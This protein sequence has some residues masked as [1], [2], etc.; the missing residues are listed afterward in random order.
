[1]KVTIH[2]V[3]SPNLNNRI[4]PTSVL[5]KAIEKYT[6]ECIKE[7]KAFVCK[8]EPTSNSVNLTEVIG[9]VI[10]MDIEDCVVTAEIEKLNINNSDN[11]WPLIE[12]GKLSV[13]QSGIGTLTQQRD[14]T[15]L[16]NDNYQLLSL[17]LTPNP[18]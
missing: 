1:M 5:Q 15:F 3:N 13:R 9:K 17:F 12:Q 10:R 11:F 14:G 7:G 8:T 6:N 2:S 16:V 18:A 4:Y